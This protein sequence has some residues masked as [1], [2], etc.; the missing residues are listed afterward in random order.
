MGAPAEG[1]DTLRRL[2]E[3]LVPEADPDPRTAIASPTQH[4]DPV[5][6]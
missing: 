2:Q 1:H 6:S 4:G 3:E 5:A